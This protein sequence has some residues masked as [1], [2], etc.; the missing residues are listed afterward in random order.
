MLLESPIL[1][2]IYRSLG[3]SPAPCI[4]MM[5]S[6]TTRVLSWSLPGDSSWT[7]TIHSLELRLRP[8]HLKHPYCNEILIPDDDYFY[9][10][11][12]EG[13]HTCITYDAI[14]QAYLDAR[15]RILVSQPKGDWHAEH[16]AS[17]G[18]LIL[19]I[20]VRGIRSTR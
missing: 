3:L 16:F 15:T 4:L 14:N 19:D 17:V 11:A 6:T 20:S 9:R 5:A 12:Y 10:L 8:L 13:K 7:T 1:A 2:G 18:E